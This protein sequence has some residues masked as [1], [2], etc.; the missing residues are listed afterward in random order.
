MNKKQV[1]I[2]GIILAGC[3]TGLLAATHAQGPGMT[4]TYTSA[5][6]DIDIDIKGASLPDG[7]PFPDAGSLGGG[8]NPNKN[9]FIGG[10][11]MGG[12]PD[13]RDLPI[14]VDFEWRETPTSPPDPTPMDPF[15]PA[16][17]DW[18]KKIMEEFY[19]YPL[20]KQRVLIRSRV[21]VEVVS[22]VLNDNLHTPKGKLDDAS[23][24]L[25]FV[26]TEYGI[27]LR[28]EIWHRN[29]MQYD[30][31]Q[32]GDE[33]VPA[34]TTMI[35]AYSSTIKND[36]VAV[37]PGGPGA[38]GRPKR[39]PASAR[40]TVFSG[41]SGFTYTSR[42]VSGG[43]KL[44]VF[45]NEP[46]LPEWV[47]FKWALLPIADLPH[48]SGESESAYHWRREAV[49][50]ALHRENER[51]PVRS[52]IPEEVCDEITTATRT[53]QPHKVASSLIYLYF[54]WTNSGIKL[55]WRL[56]RSRPDGTFVSIREG[57]D[58]ITN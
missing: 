25:Y 17:K 37:D 6:K 56:K 30:S 21:P 35:A 38:D 52:R 40:G 8:S 4:I 20:K 2:A 48:E 27:K 43:E 24:R 32:G 29:G 15:S 10:K 9:P 26:W 47:D 23:L 49:L 7:T 19:S 44:M 58:E 16:H 53:A 13:G 50:G 28:W 1:V 18:E 57:G 22:T 45:E 33:I 39:Y 31:D 54:I 14:Y 42:P 46:E 51:V 36:S 55:H 3:L 5:I 12:A 41:S 11:T 34:G